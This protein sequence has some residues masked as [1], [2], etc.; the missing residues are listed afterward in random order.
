[1]IFCAQLCPGAR[2]QR[3]RFFEMK[4]LFFPR[5]EKCRLRF[6]RNRTANWLISALLM[7]QLA[8]GLQWQTAQAVMAQAEP[9][10]YGMKASHCPTYLS[11]NVRTDQTHG[12]KSPTSAPSSHNHPA[13]KQDCCRSQGC[14]C[15]CA[16]SPMGF[17]RTLVRPAPSPSVLL[18][19]LTARPPVARSSERFRPPIA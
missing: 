7:F 1:M 5:G 4:S 15:H 12:A 3:V 18:P 13:G 2:C 17:A 19:I 10:T 11:E 16:Q 6:V 14:Q 8:I 9:Q